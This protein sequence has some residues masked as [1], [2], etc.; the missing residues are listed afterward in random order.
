M[1]VSQRNGA[2]ASG[3]QPNE[4]C[5]RRQFLLA[6]IQPDERVRIQQQIHFVSSGNQNESGSGASKS[7]AI[8][9]LP[10]CNPSTR[11]PSGG[12]SARG[13]SFAFPLA[14]SWMMTSCPACT[15]FSNSA[16]LACASSM[17]SVM[18]TATV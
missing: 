12:G 13:T 1:R 2:P 6:V 10:L 14:E 16:N 4:P 7:S 9:Q 3:L 15:S 5:C 8:H 11:G 18:L 17:L